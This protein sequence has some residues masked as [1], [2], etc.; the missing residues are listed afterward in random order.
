MTF[1]VPDPEAL[2]SDFAKN[3]ELCLQ[4]SLTFN[5]FLLFNKQL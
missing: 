3:L 2:K 5:S 4:G 1:P